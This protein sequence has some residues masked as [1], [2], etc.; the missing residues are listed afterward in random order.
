[1]D[2]VMTDAGFTIR[3]DNFTG[4]FDLLLQLIGKHKLDVTEIALHRVTDEF[5]AYI[6]AMG[7]GWQLDEA[8]EF[9]VIAAT[10]LDLKA[11]RLLPAASVEDE[12]DLALLEARDLLFARLL[13]YRAFKEAAA[14]LAELE[15]AGF[16]RYPRAVGLEPRFAEALPDLVLG[17][18]PDRLATLATRAMTP[19]PVPTVSIEHV[20]QVRVSVKEHAAVLRDRLLRVRVATFRTLCSDCRNTLEVVA[21]F[22]ALLELYREGLVGFAQVQALGELTVRWTGDAAAGVELQI[23]EYAGAPVTAE[24]RPEPDGGEDPGGRAP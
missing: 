21:R 12:E 20:H 23:D 18:G 1:V 2:L 10:L 19:R 4:P 8:S 5:L 11:A 22:L 7:D 14:H 15:S 17:I 16:R 9:L 6:R 24:Q 3:L 13:Q